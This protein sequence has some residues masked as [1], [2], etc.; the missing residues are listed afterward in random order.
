MAVVRLFWFKKEIPCWV[1]G[2]FQLTAGFSLQ[3]FCLNRS[4]GSGLFS[5]VS[6]AAA[7]CRT[8]LWPLPSPGAD[9]WL[10][11][12]FPG[13]M[14][15]SSPQSCA[16]GPPLLPDCR[17]R[18]KV[19]PITTWNDMRLCLCSLV[20]DGSSSFPFPLV[21]P[22]FIIVQSCKKKKEIFVYWNLI[23]WFPVN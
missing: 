11:G 4:W 21:H 10:F 1:R 14:A 22:Y 17:E 8:R 16:P 15:Y 18:N 2:I 20:P 19:R 5:P 7:C 9:L 3:W 23:C 13:K 6:L 12:R